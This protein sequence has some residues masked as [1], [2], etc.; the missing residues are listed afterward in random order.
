LCNDGNIALKLKAKPISIL[1]VEVY[2]PT[3]QY[4]DDEVEELYDMIEEIL[5]RMEKVRQAPS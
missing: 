5:N 4:E 1:S 3:P 2:L